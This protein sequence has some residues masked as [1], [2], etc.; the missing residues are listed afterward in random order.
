MASILPGFKRISEYAA[1]TN[2]TSRFLLQLHLHLGFSPM[3]LS[4]RRVD[5]LG[6]EVHFGSRKSGY[7]GGTIRKAVYA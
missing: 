3:F 4:D 7:T 1:C 6:R 5:N 2:W